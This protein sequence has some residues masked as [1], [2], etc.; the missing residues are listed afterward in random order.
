MKKVQ[1]ITPRRSI[2]G[3]RRDRTKFAVKAC[4]VSCKNIKEA[5]VV[6]TC[7]RGGL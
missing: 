5:L 1:W 2:L 6:V 3:R 7:E 4:Q